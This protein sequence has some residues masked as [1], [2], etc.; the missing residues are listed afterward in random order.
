MDKF[1]DVQ[2]FLQTLPIMLQG[3]IGIFFVT[4]L[5][6]LVIF[7]LNKFTNKSPKKEKDEK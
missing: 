5:I 4:G 6:I 2:L 7:L 1:F 3:M